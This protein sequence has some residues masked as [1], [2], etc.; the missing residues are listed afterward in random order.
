V[1]RPDPEWGQRVVALVVPAVGTDPPTLDG[2]RAAV[3]R[4]LPAYAAPRELR[5]VD[6]LPRTGSGK[7]ARAALDPSEPAG[8]RVEG[9]S[10]HPGPRGGVG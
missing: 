4:E 10:P 2:L 6:A 7:V 9:D 5:L 3:R 8:A 1:G